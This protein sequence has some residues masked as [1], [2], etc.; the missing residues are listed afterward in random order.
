M[1]LLVTTNGIAEWGVRRF[2]CALGR[3]G[4]VVEKREGDGAT[5]AGTLSLSRVLCR[6]DRIVQPDTELVLAAL[7]PDD[8]WCD[9]PEAANYN[10]QVR[11]PHG[12]S[13]EAL[14]RVDRVYDLIVVT[15]FN[16]APVVPHAGS[17][18]FLHV[19]RPGYAP[20]EGCIA[21]ALD[22]LR[23]I[24]SEWRQADRVRVAAD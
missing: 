4:I 8:G 16:V 7:Q 18:I 9:A 1:D 11:L 23:L 12:A 24:V 14:W 20:T 19:A 10:Q 5:P 2:R 13:C 6:L 21:F 15:D 22:D 17:A 3:S